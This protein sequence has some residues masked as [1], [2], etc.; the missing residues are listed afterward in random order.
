MKEITWETGSKRDLEKEEDCVLV[1]GQLKM[2]WVGEVNER[3]SDSGESR[4]RLSGIELAIKWCIKR[5]RTQQGMYAEHLQVCYLHLHHWTQN[6]Q[7]K[8]TEA[9]TAGLSASNV[10]TSY[11]WSPRTAVVYLLGRSKLLKVV[12]CY[13]L[14]FVCVM[15]GTFQNALVDVAAPQQQEMSIRLISSLASN[16]YND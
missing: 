2:N 12:F 11:R 3:Y 6:I 4:H 1:G 10:L 9:A 5:T 13:L 15:I 8:K 7:M 14:H 16:S